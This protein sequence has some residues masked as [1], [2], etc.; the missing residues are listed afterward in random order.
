MGILAGQP[1]AR[2]DSIPVPAQPHVPSARAA[3]GSGHPR[4]RGRFSGMRSGRIP[5][6]S[7][8]KPSPPPG[9]RTT[10]SCFAS[11]KGSAAQCSSGSLRRPTASATATTYPSLRVP[12]PRT[13]TAS[14]S[15][16][17]ARTTGVCDACGR[18]T[19]RRHFDSLSLGMSTAWEDREPGSTRTGRREEHPV[20]DVTLERSPQLWTR[21]SG[22]A[23]ATRRYSQGQ[24]RAS[25]TAASKGSIARVRVLSLRVPGRAAFR[26]TECQRAGDGI[27]RHQLEVPV[28][29]GL[30][31]LLDEAVLNHEMASRIVPTQGHGDYV[32]TVGVGDRAAVEPHLE[33]AAVRVGCRPLIDDIRVVAL[34]RSH[35]AAASTSSEPRA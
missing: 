32:E 18:C 25:R 12:G 23:G 5:K 26:S 17:T 34:T 9:G 24:G 21:R 10:R 29:H 14:R 27:P 7:R 2:V 8:R 20:A 31:R 30:A 15:E 35:A 22:V 19:I 33:R 3:T 16:T 6:E 4:R 28:L 11:F 13:T 1:R